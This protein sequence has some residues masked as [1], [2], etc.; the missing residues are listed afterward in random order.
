MR[1]LKITVK[2]TKGNCAAGYQVGDYFLVE[3]PMIIHARPTG[4]HTMENRQ[5]H[6]GPGRLVSIRQRT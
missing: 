5:V 6:S 1:K 4:L 2:S 3:E